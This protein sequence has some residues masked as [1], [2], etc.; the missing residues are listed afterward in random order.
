MNHVMVDI[1]TLGQSPGSIICSIA[2]SYFNTHNFDMGPHFYAEIDLQSCE[3]IGLKADASTVVWWLEHV[4]PIH[5]P[6][7]KGKTP[8]KEALKELEAFLSAA[9]SIWAKSPSFDLVL[10]KSAWKAANMKGELYDYWKEKDVR[11]V[12]DLVPKEVL[13]SFKR[14]SVGKEASHHASYDVQTQSYLVTSVCKWLK[15]E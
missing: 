10:L 7:F 3:E 6:Q 5:M 9:D 12:L 14:Y 13:E 15:H 4:R 1:E 2:A 11:T 8:I